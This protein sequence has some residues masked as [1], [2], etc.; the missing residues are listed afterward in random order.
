[1]QITARLTDNVSLGLKK[2]GEMIHEIDDDEIQKVLE[3][4]VQEARGG[5]PGGS[6][7]GYVVPERLGQGYVRT[8]NLGRGTYWIREGRSYRLKSDTTYARY[9]IGDGSGYGQAWMHV[10]RWPVAYQVMLK[11]AS[12]MVENIRSRIRGGAEAV[13]L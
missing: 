3:Q 1:M 10:G 6:Y 11:W 9:V 12:T 5:Y 7:S 4:A 8:G 2:L 13:G